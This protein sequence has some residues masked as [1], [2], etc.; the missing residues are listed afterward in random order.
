MGEDPSRTG[1]RTGWAERGYG[2]RNAAYEIKMQNASNLVSPNPT[3]FKVSSFKGRGWIEGVAARKNIRITKRTQ[4]L[5]KKTNKKALC[6]K[7]TNPNEA[8]TNPNKA[9]GTSETGLHLTDQ[10]HEVETIQNQ[11][12]S[13][14]IKPNQTKSNQ[15]KPNQ[16]KSE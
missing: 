5:F 12:E 7:K 8:K 11:T 16:T 9:T 1:I 2:V 15:I 10:S 13:N 4:T 3:G 14:Q 6:H